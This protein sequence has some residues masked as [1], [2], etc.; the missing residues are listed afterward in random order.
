M[1]LTLTINTALLATLVS[2]SAFADS[3]TITQNVSVSAPLSISQGN[4]TNSAQAINSIQLR[5]GGSSVTNTQQTLNLGSGDL[6]LLQSGG[7]NNHQAVNY[8][9]SP[10]IHSAAQTLNQAGNVA[11]KQQ[12]GDN[13]IQA[14]NYAKATGDAPLQ[15]LKKNVQAQHIT[16]KF[17]GIGSGN[18]QAG[19]YIEADGLP[20]TSGDVVQNLATTSL[21]YIQSGTHNLQAGNVVVNNSHTATG[22][23][24]KTFRLVM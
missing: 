23:L 8:L 13:N 24:R 22:Q 7:D 11:L 5:N 17:E 6:T 18:I 9:L 16:L 19:N 21:H 20:T 4:M 15:S 10:E 2:G 1:S 3:W 12:G 14:L